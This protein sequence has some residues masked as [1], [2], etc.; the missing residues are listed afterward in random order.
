MEH[1][2]ID[3]DQKRKELIEETKQAEKE[4]TA[5][6]AAIL[7]AV[8]NDEELSHNA[9]KWV[10]IGDAEFKVKTTLSGDT[11]D[12]VESFTEDDLPPMSSLVDAAAKQTDS[13]R[14]DDELVTDENNIMA[15]WE[16]Y[17]DEYGEAAI[18]AI[19]ARILAPAMDTNEVNQSFQGE[20]NR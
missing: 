19:Q 8:K 13:I 3:P 7:E 4:A 17:Y 5:E 12:I 14:V 16:V 2:D 11:L 1:I 18:E 9:T 10:E 15:F 20:R 6:Q